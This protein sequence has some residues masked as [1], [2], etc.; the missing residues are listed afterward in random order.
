M[1]RVIILTVTGTVT[2]DSAGAAEIDWSKVDQAF[3]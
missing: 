3:G 1:N 2:I